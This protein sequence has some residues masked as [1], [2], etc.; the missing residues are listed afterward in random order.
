MSSELE[1]SYP[2]A[3]ATIYCVI[4]RR[5]DMKVWNT[6]TSAW[7]TWAD[8]SIADYDTALANQGGDIFTGDMPTAA[9]FLTGNLTLTYYVQAGGTPAITDT[10]AGFQRVT[11]NG[12]IVT[13][14]SSVTISAYALTTLA[15]AKRY[16]NI[17]A[18]TY[19]T[20]LTEM[21][22]AVS[23]MIET[24]AGRKF[25]ARN[26]KEFY[27]GNSNAR[28]RLT[29]A[30]V[31]YVN[32]LAVGSINALTARYS[33]SAIR[34]TAQVYDS[35]TNVQTRGI[36]LQSLSAAGTT[37]ST[38]I[39]FAT[40]PTASTVATAISAVS[41]WTATLLADCAADELHPLAG[42]NAKSQAVFFTYPDQDIDSNFINRETGLIGY[43]TN[44]LGRV[45]GDNELNQRFERG[46]Q[47]ILVDYRGGFE[48]IP[49][50]LAMLTNELVATMWRG[51][52]RD[53]NLKSENL[54]DYSYT[55]A[56]VP[57]LSEAQNERAMRWSTIAIGAIG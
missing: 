43:A 40:Y 19:D 49:D 7:A 18:S 10:I 22:N 30:P 23:N 48:T 36:R 6:T 28:L 2:T 54:G 4:R 26:Y 17:S 27:S 29:N 47:N 3:A 20:I 21:I 25:L 31:I 41:G 45:W 34:A 52:T 51:S 57:A 55:L 53:G 44:Q 33:G 1:L 35:G 12:A 15:S 42:V 38:L 56:D 11:W 24:V 14:S 32:R 16:L 5:S 46:W 50:D 13:G 9:A 37:T 39:D 8:G